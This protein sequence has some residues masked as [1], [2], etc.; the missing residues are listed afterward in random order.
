[1]PFLAVENKLSVKEESIPVREEGFLAAMGCVH[2]DTTRC[3]HLCV[4]GCCPCVYVLWR[5][6][7]REK[8]GIQGSIVADCAS[9]CCCWPLAVMQDARLIKS[10]K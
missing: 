10:K 9:W 2:N 5:K 3:C 4:V 6:A 7:I 1:M 8:Y